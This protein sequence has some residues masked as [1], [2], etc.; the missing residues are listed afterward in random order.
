M[1]NTIAS[2]S[3]VLLFITILPNLYAY[4]GGNIMGQVTDPSTKQPIDGAPVVLDCQGSQ[5]V[6][7]TNEKGFYYASNIAPCT[8]T[9]IVSLM[10]KTVK[11]EHVKID[12][13]ETQKQDVA[14]NLSE[15]T[16]VLN[17][18]SAV[19]IDGGKSKNPIINAFEPEP[20]VITSKTLH[21]LPIVKATQAIETQAG[22][23]GEDGVYYVHGAREGGLAF[24]IDGCKVMGDPDVPICGVSYIKTYLNFIPA[25]Y[26]DTTGG[27]MVVETRSL[28]TE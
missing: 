3:F 14:L 17:K 20:G 5:R 22:V 19:V 16:N 2:K 13:D 4:C 21:E 27:V 15:G 9:I 6:F 28:F 18:D 23:A 11:I 7:Y 8:Y 12:N 10:G 26:G 25:K 1:K 24:Y